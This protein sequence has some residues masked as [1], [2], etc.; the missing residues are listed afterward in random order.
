MLINA[1][2]HVRI[3]SI[4]YRKMKNLLV[5]VFL[6]V[7]IPTK[8]SSLP[9]LGKGFRVEN[10]SIQK[11]ESSNV[12]LVGMWN[13]GAPRA[14]CSDSNFIYI[15]SGGGVVIFDAINNSNPAETASISFPGQ[16][17][18]DLF[19]S[20][21]LLFVADGEKGMRIANIANASNPLEIGCFEGIWARSIYAKPNLIYSGEYDTSW[22]LSIYDISNIQNPIPLGTSNAPEYWIMDLL[23]KGSYAYIAEILHGIRVFDV[24]DSS[25]PHE[26][27]SYEIPGYTLSL[28]VYDDTLLLVGSALNQSSLWV[29][30]IEDPFNPL[31]VSNDSSFFGE[32][33]DVGHF[34]HYAY[35]SSTYDGTIL[36]DIYD[37][38]NPFLVGMY[39]PPNFVLQYRSTNIGSYIYVGEWGTNE[40]LGN[41]LRTID[42]SNPSNPISV[43]YDIIPDRS[44]DI[45]IQGDYAYV[46]NFTSGM[47]VLD[48]SESTRP[49]KVANYNTPG[50]CNSIEVRDSIAYLADTASIILLNISDP[51]DPQLISELPLLCDGYGMALQYPYLYVTSEWT[52]D[53]TI[54]DVSDPQNP[55]ITGSLHLNGY[56]T[57]ISSK[58]T[59]GFVSVSAEGIAVINTADSSNPALVTYLD[60]PGY[61]RGNVIRD[62]YL[63]VA[64]W[65]PSQ[66]C[67]VNISN[68]LYPI[69]ENT[70]NTFQSYPFGIDISG[71]LLYVAEQWDAME[72]FDISFSPSLQSVGY[73]EGEPLLIPLS[74]TC[75]NNIAYL[76]ANN[77]VFIFKYAPGSIK[78]EKNIPFTGISFTCNPTIFSDELSITL[79]SEKKESIEIN[80]T[81]VSGRN[82]VCVFVGSISGRKRISWDGTNRHRKKLPTGIYFLILND[83]YN[84]QS[85]K[86]MILK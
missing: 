50:L 82:L 56:P 33:E 46:A 28:D 2:I 4:K 24:S 39:T 75:N 55:F 23:V 65:D 58:D 15:G 9:F 85:E 83:G 78:E 68:P 8:I 6:L 44:Y 51:H 13:F 3:N 16:E 76:C 48:I 17:V 53:F 62:N 19:A 52:H 79:I 84:I 26:I 35:I 74:I 30:N 47:Y 37:P 22:Q 66:I 11:R 45:S 31:L 10:E 49:V 41:A 70:I 34:S 1:K 57:Y 38:V 18:I 64:T 61:A 21:S 36:M 54:I 7:L 40:W 32:G 25:N 71:T 73:Y 29:L 63:Y 67:V 77:G 27:S 20:D 42:A 59:F 60:L 5:A 12:D 81:D 72:V 43:D 69:L 14:I 80:I 86:V